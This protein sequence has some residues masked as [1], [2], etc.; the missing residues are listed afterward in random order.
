MLNKMKKKIKSIQWID[1]LYNA[2]YGNRKTERVR[3]ERRRQLQEDGFDVVKLVERALSEWPVVYYLDYGSLL[4][5][6]RDGK[7]MD[8]DEDI[9]YSIYINTEFSWEDLQKVLSQ[10]GLSLIHQFQYN[11]EIIEQTYQLGTLTIDFFNHY[12][13]ENNTIVYWCSRNQDEKY[14]SIDQYSVNKDVA[15][16]VSGVQKIEINGL[17]FNAPNNYKDYLASI[18]SE[19]WIIP[20]PNWNH[21]QKAPSFHSLKGER[22]TKKVFY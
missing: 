1:D 4:G 18:Y 22:A 11:N 15:M 12:D 7:F 21:H 3:A 17:S 16:K 19:K 9:D 8:Y 2:V 14:E 20:D 6:V 10:N 13:D 5:M